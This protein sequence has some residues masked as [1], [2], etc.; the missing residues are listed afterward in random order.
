MKL[1]NG[2]GTGESPVFS[3]NAIYQGDPREETGNLAKIS[4]KN[5]S[6]NLTVP[7]DALM[8][9]HKIRLHRIVISRLDIFTCDES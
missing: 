4:A 6:L 2:E 1:A 7:V 5:S 8:G 3:R 9:S